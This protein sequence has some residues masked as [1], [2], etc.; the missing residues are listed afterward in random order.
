MTYACLSCESE[1]L[2]LESESFSLEYSLRMA[3][4]AVYL[5]RV[6]NYLDSMM[7]VSWISFSVGTFTFSRA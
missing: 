2:S 1:S 7:P 4:R 5:K 3:L 6:T